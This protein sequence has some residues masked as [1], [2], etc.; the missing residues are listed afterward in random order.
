MLTSIDNHTTSQGKSTTDRLENLGRIDRAIR[1]A[2]APAAVFT[3]MLFQ[4]NISWQP[5]V[6]YAGV[7]L[8]A[9][10]LTI[11]DPLYAL[12]RLNTRRINAEK[13]STEPDGMLV[14]LHLARQ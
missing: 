1:A 6:T 12:L 8:A 3:M 7:Y 10:A 4:E 11:W 14:S 5:Y 13:R 9:T 2:F